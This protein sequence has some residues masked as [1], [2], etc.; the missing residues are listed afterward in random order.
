MPTIERFAPGEF[1]W[2][3][4]ATSDRNAAK[5][6][7]SALFGWAVRD[8]PIGP[9][10]TY[11]LLELD[12]R[13]A[14]GAFTLSPAESAAGISPH[15]HLYVAVSSAD[16]AATKVAELGGKVVEAFDVGD[17]GR[18]ALIQDPTGAFL[19]LW[20]PNKRSG[21]G[22]TGEPG[23]FCWADLNTP[24]QTRAKTFYEGLFG[25]KL[26]AGE[27]KG[28]G[29]L[30]IVNGENYIGGVPPARPSG[31]HQPPHWL[32]YFAV[33]DVDKTFNR[34]MDLGAR[35][36]LRPMDFEGVGRVAMLADPQGA[37]FALYREAA[38]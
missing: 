7:Y 11:S 17:R 13:I 37:V 34:A 20:E 21:L 4:L 25:W 30:H 29:Y 28:S 19:S 32:I 10:D 36:L 2:I 27:G 12:G 6:F 38:K 22:V 24:D 33:E 1:C 16:E 9:N 3:E 8:V 15:W 5:S 14:A 31:A 23:S 18:A 35:V 26:K